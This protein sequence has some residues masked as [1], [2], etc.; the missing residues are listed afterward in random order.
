[1]N[2]DEYIDFLNQIFEMFD[3][4]PRKPRK[5]KADDIRL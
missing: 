2:F 4:E 1:M 3:V 5:M